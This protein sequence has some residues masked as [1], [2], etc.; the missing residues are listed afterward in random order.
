MVWCGITMTDK[1]QLHIVQWWVTGQYYRDNIIEPIVVPF[2]RQYGRRFIFQ[3]DNVRAHR[4]RLVTAHMQQRNITTM[5]WPALSPDLS[6]IEHVWDIMG[7]R[8]R[9]RQRQSTNL[10]ELTVAFQEEW[11][12]IPQN[13]IGSLISS[14]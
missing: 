2:A 9:R 11:N 13:A 8:L 10:D 1:T 4:S 7:R 6:P 5:P 12:G 14:M 3:D